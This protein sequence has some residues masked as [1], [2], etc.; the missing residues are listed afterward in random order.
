[1][2]KTLAD[3]PDA[4]DRFMSDVPDDATTFDEVK[5]ALLS[6]HGQAAQFSDSQAEAMADAAVTE[7][8]VLTMIANSGRVPTSEEVGSFVAAA[9]DDGM[10]GR[11]E[12]VAQA[13]QDQIAVRDDIEEA[14]RSADPTFREDVKEAVS[15]ATSGKQVVGGSEEE[16]VDGLSRQASAPSRGEVASEVAQAPEQ[17]S[18]DSLADVDSSGQVQV[19]RDTSGEAVSV[20]ASGASEDAART[21]AD[22]LGASYEGSGASGLQSVQDSIEV[23]GQGGGRA[24]LRLRGEEIGEVRV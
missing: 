21:V 5:D 16:L 3:Y 20:V 23:E 1:M 24:S 7:G 15:S 14:V 19:V 4:R 6:E 2:A 22:E 18:A 12:T 10:S 11:R 9:D 17:A 13:I 8:D